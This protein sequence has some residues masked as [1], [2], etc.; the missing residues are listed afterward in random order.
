M[1][2]THDLI[3]RRTGLLVLLVILVV[4]V[5]GE[6]VAELTPDR[7]NFGHVAYAP[8]FVTLN[9]DTAARP[10]LRVIRLRSPRDT[11]AW[12]ESL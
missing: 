9:V 3:E 11:V 1:K 10:D 6:K 12:L 8:S 4:S 7:E 5:G 2:I